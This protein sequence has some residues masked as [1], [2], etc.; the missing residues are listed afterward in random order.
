MNFYEYLGVKETASTEEIRKAFRKVAKV[1]HPDYNKKDSAFWEMVELNIIRDTLLHPEKRKK[2][3]LSLRLGY[4]EEAVPVKNTHRKNSRHNQTFYKSVRSFFIYHCKICGI[5]L[6]S[7]WQG[8]CL[9]HYLESTGQLNNEDFIFEYGGQRYRWADPPDHLKK[10][11]TPSSDT[12]TAVA[13]IHPVHIMLYSSLILAIIIY[14][15]IFI[16]ASLQ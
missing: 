5:E 15:F 12:R 6:S 7:T 4:T 9:L 10:S 11:N 2:Y 1:T 8:Y 3:D 16:K 13:Q 14:I